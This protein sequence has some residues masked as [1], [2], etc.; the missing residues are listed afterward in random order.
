MNAIAIYMEGGGD[1]KDTKASLRTGMDGFLSE[2][3]DLAPGKSRR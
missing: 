3:K 1:S 2:L